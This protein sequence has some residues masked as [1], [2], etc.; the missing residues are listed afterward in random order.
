M[1]APRS[2]WATAPVRVVRQGPSGVSAAV[3]RGIAESGEELVALLDADDLWPLD[4]LE[5]QVAALEDGAGVEAVFGHARQ[6]ASPDLEPSERDR[7][8]SD[9]EPQPFRSKGTML[10]QR[11]ALDRVGP[12]DTRWRVGDFVDWHARAEEAGLRSLMLD[13]VQLHRRL[14]AANLGLSSRD[15]GSTTPAWLAQPSS[16]AGV[17]PDDRRRAFLLAPGAALAPLARRHRVACRGPGRFA[18]DSRS[19]SRCVAGFVG[20]PSARG[21]RRAGSPRTDRPCW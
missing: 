1:Q 10:I 4:K 6:F 18:N 9:P 3:N 8:A 21:R 19:P 7:L 20:R 2:R 12:F 13:R 16:G 14:H 15:A 5:L 17:G 11:S